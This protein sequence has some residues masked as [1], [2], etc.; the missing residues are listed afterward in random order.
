MEARGHTPLDMRVLTKRGKEYVQKMDIAPGFPGNPLT[1]KDHLQRFRDCIGFAAKPL[2][3]KN[4]DRI[5]DAAEHLD[6]MSDIR[7]LISLLMLE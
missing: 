6:T 7:S 3:G 4:I 2:P 1:G 5:A